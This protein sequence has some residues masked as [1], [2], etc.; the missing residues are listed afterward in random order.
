M[1]RYAVLL[2]LILLAAAD[3]HALLYYANSFNTVAAIN[4]LT[5]S[6]FGT[7]SL[8]I[9]LSGSG[10]PVTNTLKMEQT[11]SGESDYLY[12][13]LPSVP[14]D[15]YVYVSVCVYAPDFQG[16]A[17]GGEG[18][19][20]WAGNDSGGSG[21]YHDYLTT[22]NSDFEQLLIYVQKVTSSPSALEVLLHTP[23]GTSYWDDLRVDT[24]PPPACPSLSGGVPTATPTPGPTATPSIDGPAVDVPGPLPLEPIDETIDLA[25][26]WNIDAISHMVSIIQT[27]FYLENIP[28]FFKI[29]LFIMGVVI[30]LRLVFAIIGAR[31]TAARNNSGPQV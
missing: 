23:Q 31:Q 9:S 8:T 3:V 17:A 12:I 20:V 16:A 24:E 14:D 6:D 25:P 21:W 30:G 28:E 11:L 22:G 27:Y 1:K 15:E 13:I 26:F 4:E 10:D 5:V 7:Q 2:V 29:F 19:K 18:L